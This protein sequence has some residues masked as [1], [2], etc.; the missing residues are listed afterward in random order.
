MP[1]KVGQAGINQVPSELLGWLGGNQRDTY[2]HVATRGTGAR[3][4]PAIPYSWK[5]CRELV[6]YHSEEGLYMLL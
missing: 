4:S 5:V 3:E 2:G 6:C 1:G